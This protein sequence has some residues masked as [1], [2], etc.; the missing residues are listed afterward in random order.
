[1]NLVDTVMRMKLPE[2]LKVLTREKYGI[3][4]SSG[5]AG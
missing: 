5:F 3:K 2:T 1:M 4:N